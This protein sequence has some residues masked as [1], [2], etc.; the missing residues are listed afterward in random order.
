MNRFR[1]RLKEI[2]IQCTD[3]SLDCADEPQD[4]FIFFNR[5]R[6]QEEHKLQIDLMKVLSYIKKNLNENGY[7]VIGNYFNCDGDSGVFEKILEGFGF[8]I[9]MKEDITRNII[10]SRRVLAK[11]HKNRK[12]AWAGVKVRELIQLAY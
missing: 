2:E 9:E 4:V 3:Y 8:R 6:E 11:I 1:Y 12:L 10:H 7:A 5:T